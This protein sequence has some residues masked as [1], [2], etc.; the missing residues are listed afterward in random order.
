VVHLQLFDGLDG[1][2]VAH[3]GDAWFHD[4]GVANTEKAALATYFVA[5]FEHPLMA[6]VNQGKCSSGLVVAGIV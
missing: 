1:G 2:D 3:V 6:R 4:C 5:A